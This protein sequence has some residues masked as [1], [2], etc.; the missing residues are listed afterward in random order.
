VIDMRTNKLVK[1]ISGVPGITGLEFVPGARKV[2]TSDWGEEK[3]AVVDPRSNRKMIGPSRASSYMNLLRQL[4][5]I[6]RHGQN[7]SSH[8][9]VAVRHLGEGSSE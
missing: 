5:A 2:Y 6:L 3:I 4:G 7:A 1:A 8:F 9:A